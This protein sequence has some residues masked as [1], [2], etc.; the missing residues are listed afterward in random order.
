[1]HLIYQPYQCKCL[2]RLQQLQQDCD[3]FGSITAENFW[4]QFLFAAQILCNNEESIRFE[5]NS[6]FFQRAIVAW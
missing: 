2:M 6:F 5:F 1:M 3:F 4:R